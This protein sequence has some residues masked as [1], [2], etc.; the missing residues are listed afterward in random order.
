M[1]RPH[2]LVAAL[3]LAGC[4]SS[5]QPPPP[6]DVVDVSAHVHDA[7]SPDVAPSDVTDA[8]P[9][10]DVASRCVNG[11]A[12]P[13]PDAPARID[14]LRPLPDLR[15]D[16]AAGVAALHDFYAPC[17][18]APQVLLIR[19]LT[20]WSGPSQHAAAHTQRLLAHPQADR[21]ALLDLLALGP[22]NLPATRDDLTAWRARYDAAPTALAIDPQ[23]RF[24]PLY[25]SVGE[26]P[27]YVFVDTRSMRVARVLT[28]PSS[29]E[30]EAAIT[31]ALASIDGLP[32]PRTP[33]A[34]PLVDGRFTRDEWEMIQAMRAPGAPPPDPSN[35]VADDP[36]AARLGE[37]LFNDTGFSS[38]NRVACASCHGASTLFTDGR[39]RAVGVGEGARNTPTTLLAP[40]AR[41]LLWDGRVDTLWAQALGPIENP[42][43]MRF[44]RLA[45]VRR[46]ADRYAMEYA[47][48]FGPLP[49]LSDATRFPAAAMPGDAS[50]EAMTPVDREAVNRAYVNLGKS[51]AAY[52][53]TLR[54]PTTAFDRYVAGDVSALTA[55]QRDGLRFFFV[56]GCAQCHFG[57]TLSNDSFH[58]IGMPTGH[59]DGVP[60]RGR[61]DAIAGLMALPFR[62]DGPFSD[63]RTA[64]AHLGRVAS[65]PM[66]VGQFHTPSLRG[67]G[68]TGPWGHGGNFATLNDVVLHYAGGLTLEP[69]AGTAGPRDMHLLWFHISDNVLTPMVDLLN[70]L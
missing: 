53:R 69:L 37:T 40:Y 20:S 1:K 8:R 46:L 67:I 5:P 16:T 59:A 43:E 50:W 28:R 14:E 55:S 34:E 21:V 68:R 22:D 15:F 42:S 19:T 54:F 70:A 25:L 60:D 2:S 49:D 18:T 66:Q 13:Y 32:R 29:A 39:P 51:L 7:A 35:R 36:R 47:A 11:V 44:T 30:L 57:P 62:S 63:D 61:A 4:G 24:N 56:N 33:P 3:A 6:A 52:E 38:N 17:A 58:N 23:Y 12:L 48:L 65:H 45:A 10:S 26:L 64:G 41:W 27:L 9:M 31:A